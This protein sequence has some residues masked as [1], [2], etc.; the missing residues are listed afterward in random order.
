MVM[1]R[2]RYNQRT[3]DSAS[4]SGSGGGQF[5]PAHDIE[6]RKRMIHCVIS[7]DS[8]SYMKAEVK[9]EF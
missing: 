5:M 9:L 8:S 2:N 6:I 4:G 1:A 7:I 3:P